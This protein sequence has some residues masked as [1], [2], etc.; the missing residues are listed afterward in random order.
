MSLVTYSNQNPNPIAETLLEKPVIK[1]LSSINGNFTKRFTRQVPPTSAFQADVMNAGGV[2]MVSKFSNNGSYSFHFETSATQT[3]DLSKLHFEITDILTDGDNDVPSGACDVF[4][5]YN[6][7]A[8][9]WSEISVQW[10]AKDI[11]KVRYVGET[12]SLMKK[13]K[14]SQA[15][16]DTFGS[17][18]NL[19][20]AETR[21]DESR[22]YKEN[23]YNWH[24]DCL[25]ICETIMP[26]NMRA[27]IRLT[28]VSSYQK[29]AVESPAD[30][31]I[32]N[33]AATYKYG[34][35]NIQMF[36]ELNEGPLSVA[37]S[38]KEYDVRSMTCQSQPW[39]GLA[40]SKRYDV[41]IST[42]ELIL[43]PAHKE[44]YFKLENS[45]TEFKPA[46]LLQSY[47]ITYASQ[48]F[49]DYNVDQGVNGVE[50][51]KGLRRSYY[52]SLLSYS[53]DDGGCISYEEWLLSKFYVF[54][55]IKR[56]DDLATIADVRL[57]NTG[58]FD[59]SEILLFARHSQVILVYYNEVGQVMSVTNQIV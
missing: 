39:E 45:P 33:T 43:A 55:V 47:E 27:V 3:C 23:S 1:A 48:K 16:L 41:P 18:Q 8:S 50:S 31:A 51:A 21:K 9:L 17:V 6:H 37:N 28:P 15:Y 35:T 59:G 57:T 30:I 2:A 29:T 24:P 14:H 42:Y 38:V 7:C 34:V 52:E 20:N 58:P 54:R 12:D 19:S 40:G 46:G 26:P 25:G 49:P 5:S 4:R 56:E 22:L 11:E 32:G 13:L 44:R 10:H 53:S 36:I